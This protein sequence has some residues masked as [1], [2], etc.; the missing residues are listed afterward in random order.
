MQFSSFITG[1][2]LIRSDEDADARGAPNE[3]DVM[4][5]LEEDYLRE[6]DEMIKEEN[7]RYLKKEEMHGQRE[8][9]ERC[10]PDN[11]S[12]VNAWLDCFV[13]WMKILTLIELDDPL[14]DEVIDGS[15]GNIVW[16]FCKKYTDLTGLEGKI[17]CMRVYF[18]FFLLCTQ[19]THCLLFFTI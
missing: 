10:F 11:A 1:R 17:N 5:N 14:T 2:V 3:Q 4:S 13:S 8:L 19:V 7:Y 9:M 6:L 16:D 12:K 15:F 18:N